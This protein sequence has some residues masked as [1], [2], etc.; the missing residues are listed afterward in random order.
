MEKK[1]FLF[2]I[3]LFLLAIMLSPLYAQN[4]SLVETLSSTNP[5]PPVITTETISQIS[6]D[7]DIFIIT[8]QNGGFY[9]G[10]FITLLKNSKKAA[11]ALVAKIEDGVAGI[12]ILKI[13]SLRL[14]SKKIQKQLENLNEQYIQYLLIKSTQL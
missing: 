13:H 8:A 2:Y 11:R 6:K 7:G 12:K 9:K 10:D 3:V 5:A 1:N 14:R 4:P